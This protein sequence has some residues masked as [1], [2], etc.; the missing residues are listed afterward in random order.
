MI[1]L[2]NTCYK[3]PGFLLSFKNGQVGIFNFK[4]KKLDFLTE[5]NHS[6][7]IFDIEFKPDDENIFATSSFDGF[8]RLWDVNKM[9]FIK[10][11]GA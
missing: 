5:P 3:D 6:E 10:S 7:T 8:I 11:L 2:R 1:S 9:A 4:T